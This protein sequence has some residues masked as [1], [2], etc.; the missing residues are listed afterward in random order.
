MRV[1]SG[2]I[3]RGSAGE[4]PGR[5]LRGLGAGELR[6]RRATPYVSKGDAVATVFVNNRV[7][8]SQAAHELKSEITETLKQLRSSDW[9][10]L[11]EVQTVH[12]LFVS[13]CVG[14]DKVFLRFASVI[15]GFYFVP[16]VSGRDPARE[17]SPVTDDSKPPVER[18]QLKPTR[19][20]R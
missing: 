17:A 16:S 6:G 2:Q 3:S 10:I 15:A 8:I 5:G 13:F 18:T 7:R 1:S 11:D 19:T 12:C 9:H 20:V 14:V 4:G